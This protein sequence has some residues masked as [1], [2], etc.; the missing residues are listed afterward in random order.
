MRRRAPVVP[1]ATA[2]T[3]RDGVGIERCLTC[4]QPT[5]DCYCQRPYWC[6]HC[7]EVDGSKFLHTDNRCCAAC[8]K[9]GRVA[10][11]RA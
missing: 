6:T 4:L 1:T 3:Y 5:D 7:W 9:L 2:T 11:F 10:R 8:L